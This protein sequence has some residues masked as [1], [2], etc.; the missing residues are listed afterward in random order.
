ML[1][2]GRATIE[3]PEHFR[4]VAGQGE[5]ISVQ[6]TPRYADTFGLAAVR[7]TREKIEVRE[8]KGG[9][10]TYQFDYFIT[11]T[12]A[13]FEGH[14]PIQP[15]THFTADMK[16][17]ADFE[18]TYEKTDDPTVKALRRL[19]ISN[20]I[21]TREGKLDRETAAKLGWTVKDG[22]AISRGQ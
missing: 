13:G 15:N 21:L 11:A 10:S 9:T 1:R 22:E 2:G 3:M 12:R 18:K 19:L 16:T 7:V 6:L 4:M 14:E 17:A 8:L 5:G 20:G